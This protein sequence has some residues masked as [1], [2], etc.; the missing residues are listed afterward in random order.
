MSRGFVISVTG[1]GL[2]IALM[3]FWVGMMPDNPPQIPLSQDRPEWV[4]ETAVYRLIGQTW[5]DVAAADDGDPRHFVCTF[6]GA[7]SSAYVESAA[8]E[9]EGEITKLEDVR[10]LLHF[11]DGSEVYLKDN[12]IMT[13]Y[14]N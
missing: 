4:P 3:F 5:I 6:Y 13:M 2:S 12:R 9:L 14:F 10:D 1:F 7:H 11:F 8:F